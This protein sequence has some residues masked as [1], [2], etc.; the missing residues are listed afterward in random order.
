MMAK[1]EKEYLQSLAEVCINEVYERDELYAMSDW[2]LE[3]EGV[4]FGSVIGGLCF[5]AEPE[6]K[7]KNT[8]IVKEFYLSDE[9]EA[10]QRKTQ[11]KQDAKR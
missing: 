6:N 3:D 7:K 9:A 5:R 8:W 1:K 10:L 2:F 11:R 4:M